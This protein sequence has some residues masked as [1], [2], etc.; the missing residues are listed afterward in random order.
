[1]EILRKGTQ[2]NVSASSGQGNSALP[3]M[4]GRAPAP[5]V[6]RPQLIASAA[7]QPKLAAPPVYRPLAVSASAM[8]PMRSAAPPVYRP[9]PATPASLQPMRSAQPWPSPYQSQQRTPF[10]P[11]PVPNGTHPGAV[12]R[13]A[14]TRA[15]FHPVPASPS[16][17]RAADFAKGVQPGPKNLFA[18]APQPPRLFP[19]GAAFATIQLAKRIKLQG[20]VNTISSVAR[21]AQ[22]RGRR[23]GTNLSRG[24]QGSHRTAHRVGFSIVR[25]N[26][27]GKSLVGGRTALGTVM[28]R[29]NTLRSVR[30]LNGQH[31]QNLVNTLAL[32][33]GA[34]TLPD[35]E[36]ASETLI[37]FIN[38]IPGA[39]SAIGSLTGHGESPN[40]R[41]LDDYEDRLRRGDAQ[42]YT[43]TQVA[44]SMF[45]LLD[46]QPGATV[47]DATAAD[48]IYRHCVMLR[49][50]WP[51]SAV[52]ARVEIL[53]YLNN[54][55]RA[56]FLS[57]F[58]G[59]KAGNTIFLVNTDLT[60]NGTLV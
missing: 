51:L 25:N 10:A 24:R 1:M 3:K 57:N 23:R 59:I 44:D 37:D 60:T 15:P 11:Q 49:N 33:N 12:Q 14:L 56:D 2:A 19:T 58:T 41:L 34:A 36:V 16:P 55:V 46:Y 53:Y 43:R 42:R 29:L 4:A 31:R 32:I 50:G 20:N 17:V 47:L 54:S 48:V 21:P 52:D 38:L 8:Q 22:G 7:M 30:N 9:Q 26:L 39:S 18:S 45:G 40:A 27:I 6:Y 13:S 5:P 28:T 35:M